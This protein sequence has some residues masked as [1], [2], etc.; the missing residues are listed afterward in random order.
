[1]DS[2]SEQGRAVTNIMSGIT[3]GITS[4]IRPK[5]TDAN[6]GLGATEILSKPVTD[7]FGT[8]VEKKTYTEGCSLGEVIDQEGRVV[9]FTTQQENVVR[10]VEVGK[11]PDTY[12]PN[13]GGKVIADAG[14]PTEYL[15]VVQSKDNTTLQK[16]QDFRYL[17]KSEID[18][19][20]IRKGQQAAFQPFVQGQGGR[21]IVIQGNVTSLFAL[22]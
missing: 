9:S 12:N 3:E 7:S 19:A 15:L 13:K 4:I 8:F 22:K 16:R 14:D 17:D 21:Q 2:N 5:G 11:T 10:A 6:I 1:M 18:G 20:V